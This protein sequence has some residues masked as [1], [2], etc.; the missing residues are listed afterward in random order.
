[1]TR[2]CLGCRDLI[3]RGSYCRRIYDRDRKTSAAIVQALP[4]CEECGAA[5]DLTADHII[6]VSRGGG[7]WPAARSL[8]ELQL[9]ASRPTGVML[10]KSSGRCYDLSDLDAIER[11]VVA[12]VSRDRAHPI[13]R[14][15][16]VFL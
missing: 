4:R 14:R 1:V 8:S 6:P 3:R 12:R 11:D 7:R 5:R 2:R 10:T 15:A 9:E 16:C 13:A